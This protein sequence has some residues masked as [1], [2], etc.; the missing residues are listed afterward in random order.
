MYWFR[1]ISAVPFPRLPPI[2]PS[3]NIST[4]LTSSASVSD[5]Y[6]ASVKADRRA[7]SK[8]DDTDPCLIRAVTFVATTSNR[9]GGVPA[10]RSSI[11]SVFLTLASRAAPPPT[12]CQPDQIHSQYSLPAL[13]STVRVSSVAP[14]SSWVWSAD[15]GI[16]YSQSGMLCRCRFTEVD[17]P[18]FCP[19]RALTEAAATGFDVCSWP[20]W[21][22]SE[23]RLM[24]SR[25]HKQ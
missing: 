10:Y 16:K 5:H 8:P 7:V 17:G 21:H 15:C 20:K 12:C 19:R 11:C 2:S 22:G 25:M 4:V 14:V 3:V 9:V 23:S 18:H 1:H 6:S 24:N 13:S